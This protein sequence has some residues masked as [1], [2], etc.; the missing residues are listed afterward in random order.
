MSS[1]VTAIK[2]NRLAVQIAG[3]PDEDCEFSTFEVVNGLHGVI[4]A[5]DNALITHSDVA[6]AEDLVQA[7]KVLSGIIRERCL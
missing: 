4:V 1:N 2:K 5:L 6:N 3:S 7:A